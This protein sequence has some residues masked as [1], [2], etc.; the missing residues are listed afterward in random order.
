M[1]FIKN[2]IT[3]LGSVAVLCALCELLLPSGD[4][5]KYARLAAGLLVIATAISPFSRGFDLNRLS[6]DIQM[7]T[8]SAAETE[9]EFKARILMKHK[10]NIEKL[11]AQRAGE[12]Y[13]IQA[14]VNNDGAV[15]SV[16]FDKEPPPGAVRYI[17]GELGVKEENIKV[18]EQAF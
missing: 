7:Q 16:S 4:I 9:A 15:V 13:K 2:Y 8:V 5:K 10:E 18:Y 1:E 6:A 14:D 12:G 17:T 11:I 3:S